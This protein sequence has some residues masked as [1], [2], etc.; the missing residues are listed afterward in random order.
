VVRETLL[1]V[2]K[3]LTNIA[4]HK[5]P[6]MI[7]DYIVYKHVNESAQNLI[8]KLRGRGRKRVRVMV[9]RGAKSRNKKTKRARKI[10]KKEHL[11]LVSFSHSSEAFIYAAEKASFSSEFDI[12]A[13]R[14]IQTSVLGAIETAYNPIAPQIK[15]I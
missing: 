4:E 12:Y 8:S 9:C 13:H 14:T 1:T 3:T 11:L 10:I 5:S 7:G 15:T 2:S 6:Q